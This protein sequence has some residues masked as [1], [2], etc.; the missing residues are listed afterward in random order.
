MEY[1][2]NE[3]GYSGAGRL[4]IRLLHN[5]AGIYTLEERFVNPADWEDEG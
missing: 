3:R 4:I 5:L 2:K 1:P